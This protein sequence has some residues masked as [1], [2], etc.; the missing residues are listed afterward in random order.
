MP[1]EIFSYNDIVGKRTELEGFRIAHI[2]QNGKIVDGI[3]GGVCQL[4]ST[5]YNVVLYAN[6]EIVERK[7]HQFLP[8]YIEAGRD[9]TVTDEY[10]DFKFKNTRE[11]PIKLICS[12]ENGI[13]KVQMYGKKEKNEYD[14]EIKSIITKTIP[15]KTIYEKDNTIKK[16]EQVI[17]Q[18]GKNG[19]V[20]ET[21][22]ITKTNGE[23]LSKILI[24]TDQYNVMNKI[25][26]IGT[27]DIN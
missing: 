20:S 2:Y 24:S 12:A 9:A 25:I 6:L 7:N 14:I 4:S 1:Q 18:N 10:V 26:K 21:Y 17:I 13:L 5:L 3:G 11:Y 16:G 22:K 8:E 15:Y 27:K 23:V 19:Y